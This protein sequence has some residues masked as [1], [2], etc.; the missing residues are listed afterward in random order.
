MVDPAE[1]S[2]AFGR[3]RA[4][5]LDCRTALETVQDCDGGRDHRVVDLMK[6]EGQ[7]ALLD[8]V[9]PATGAVA[10]RDPPRPFGAPSVWLRQPRRVAGRGVAEGRVARSP[11]GR[12]P[13]LAYGLALLVNR[14]A[15][16]RR[17]VV[18][19]EGATIGFSIRL[20]DGALVRVPAGRVRFEVDRHRAYYAPRAQAANHLPGALG[21]RI[22]GELDFVPFDEA[23]EDVL[24]PGDRVELLGAVE[25]R[26]DRTAE[27]PSPRAPAPTVLVPVGTPRLRRID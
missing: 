15:V 4:I 19:R 9:W 25:L 23:L 13:C 21:I 18:W 27:R 8:E 20:E 22:T 14:P 12:E 24:R 2:G 5:C 17:D 7:E 3:W 10:P 16:P 26:E 11:L 6:P 1:T